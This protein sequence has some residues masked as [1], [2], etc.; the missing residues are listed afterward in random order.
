LRLRHSARCWQLVETTGVVVAQPETEAVPDSGPVGARLARE[1]K[2]AP[3][4]PYLEVTGSEEAFALERETESTTSLVR[5]RWRVA[6]VLDGAWTNLRGK[7]A[8]VAAPGQEAEADRLITV[9][10]DLARVNLADG[11]PLAAG[12]TRLGLPLP[13]APV[14]PELRLAVGDSLADAV[15]KIFGAQGF[16]MWANTEGTLADVDPEFLHDLRVATRRARQALRLFAST[17]GK[18]EAQELRMELAWVGRLLG[19]VR[20]LDV[21]TVNIEADLRRA[22][23]SPGVR[24]TVLAALQRQRAPRLGNLREALASARFHDLVSRLRGFAGSDGTDRGGAR[25]AAGSL[26]RR[27]ARKLARLVE[28]EGDTVE[29]AQLHRIRIAFKKLRYTLEFFADLFDEKVHDAIRALIAFQ[30]CLG[31]HQDA[32]VG[33]A[34]LERL[35]GDLVPGAGQGVGEA[36]LLLA[37]GA[38]MQLQR[39]RVASERERFARERAKLPK[40][41]RRLVRSARS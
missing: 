6:A 28:R 3:L 12:L 5:C 23:A 8:L 26:S 18:P 4:L 36:D 29:D 30:D 31:A 15:A 9:L 2:G 19:E 24:S 37:F 13:G 10:R 1:A 33:L 22:A 7:L 20:D 21:F 25:E 40:L 32:V 27:Q 38:L 41:L 17:V 11:D 14:P 39:D 16:K 34:S 35:A